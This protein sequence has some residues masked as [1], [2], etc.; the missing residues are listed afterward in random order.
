MSLISL[1]MIRENLPQGLCL[2]TVTEIS[3]KQACRLMWHSVRSWTSSDAQI[4]IRRLGQVGHIHCAVLFTTLQPM[5]YGALQ[6][7][8]RQGSAMRLNI[9]LL[10]KKYEV[11]SKSRFLD[12]AFGK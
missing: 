2:A 11:N 7:S 5:L 4:G 9:C 1:S 12:P 8:V 10:I 3:P 6:P